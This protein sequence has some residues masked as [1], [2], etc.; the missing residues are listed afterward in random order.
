MLGRNTRNVSLLAP[1]TSTTSEKTQKRGE[2]EQEKKHFTERYK[3]VFL[4]QNG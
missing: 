3:A 4:A 2:N 1:G